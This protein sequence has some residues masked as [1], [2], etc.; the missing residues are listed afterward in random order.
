[1]NARIYDLSMLAGLSAIVAGVHML[2]GLPLALIAG[3]VCI[4]AITAFGALIG[5]RR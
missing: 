1:M 5:G 3:G 2:G 4:I